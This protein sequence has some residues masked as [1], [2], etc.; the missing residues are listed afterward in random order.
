MKEWAVVLAFWKVPEGNVIVDGTEPPKGKVE[1]F[2]FKQIAVSAEEA[3]GRTCM[4]I[5]SDAMKREGAALLIGGGAIPWAAFEKRQKQV[6]DETFAT[7]QAKAIDKPEAS[8]TMETE[9]K[10]GDT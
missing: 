8:A 3:V 9:I 7:E 1:E 4:A 6:A 10:R 2:A 5:W